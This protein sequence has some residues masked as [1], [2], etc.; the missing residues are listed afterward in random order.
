M[1]T[2]GPGAVAPGQD[3]INTQQDWATAFLSKLGIAPTVQNTADLV[4]WQE[5]E[6]GNWNN[7]AKYNPLNTT[8][9]EPGSA[10]IN[11]V[12]VKSYTSWSQGLQATASTLQVNAY[13]YPAIV[14]DLQNNAPLAQFE[15]DV[16]SSS[17]GTHFSSPG[18]GLYGPGSAGAGAGDVAAGPTPTASPLLSG[19]LSNMLNG[20]SLI[21]IGII[22]FLGLV[23]IVGLTIA[24]NDQGTQSVIKTAVTK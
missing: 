6:G 9:S 24:F 2:T 21:R 8:L 17:W 5:Q 20:S 15:T 22:F 12:G 23:A 4:A 19:G 7:S 11:S 1:T 16:N 13:G 14:S 18:S 3:T 10:A